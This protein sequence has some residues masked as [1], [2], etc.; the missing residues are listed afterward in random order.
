MGANDFTELIAWQRADELE[1]FALEMIKRPALAVDE[2]F[3]EQTS[4]CASSGPRK[5][6]EGH[7]KQTGAGSFG[8]AT[9]IPVVSTSQ[10]QR[11]GHRAASEPPNHEP[12]NQV[13]P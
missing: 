5:I 4:D 9:A 2:T 1:R 6:A 7:G 11:K 8:A 3:C 12:S 13:S 10:R